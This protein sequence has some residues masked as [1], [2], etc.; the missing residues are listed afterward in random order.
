MFAQRPVCK[1]LLRLYSPC[2]RLGND[3]V[4]L[5]A[6]RRA[7]CDVAAQRGVTPGS[8]GVHSSHRHGLARPRRRQ[9]SHR[10]ARRPAPDAAPLL[11]ERLQPASGCH[12]WE[13]RG[14][15]PPNWMLPG[16]LT[17]SLV[18]EPLTEKVHG[19]PAQAA[20]SS[21]AAGRLESGA[22]ELMDAQPAAGTWGGMKSRPAKNLLRRVHAAAQK[23][24]EAQVPARV[25]ST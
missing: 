2:P 21:W 5:P 9:V 16:K 23:R 19:V 6:G 12:F 3:P 25:P 11:H 8:Q 4:S 1:R 13:S 18:R 10:A 20:P 15:P 22:A 14:P 24:D 17:V 7:H